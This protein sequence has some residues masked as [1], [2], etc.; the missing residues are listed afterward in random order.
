MPRALV[1]GAG[2][3]IGSHLVKR[4]KKDGFWVRGADLKNPEFSE[5]EADDFQICD[6]RDFSQ[7]ETIF[8]ISGAPFDEVY[9][10]AAD[11]GGATYINCGDNDA[12]VVTNS[13]QINMN[14]ARLATSNKVGK[15][16]FSSSA[17]VYNKIN[18]H[19]LCVE[20]ETYPA[21]PDNE[22]GWEKIFSER[23]F[24]NYNKNYGLNV[25][26]ARFHSIIGPESAWTGG[27]EK[28]HSAL[29]R[30][31][32]F[33]ENHGVVD[34]IGDGTQKRTFLYIDD[35][36]DA[37]RLLMNKKVIDPVNIGSDH[38]ISITNYLDILKDIS[39]KNF[40]INYISGP[41]GIN[42]R[43]CPI[44]KLHNY[45]KWKPSTDISTAT[46]LTYK[47]IERQKNVHA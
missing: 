38:L 1:L 3:F 22:Y 29:A 16:F 40:T 23:M 28:A 18:D 33:V 30:K 19:A 46:A 37:I 34:V 24:Q 25:Q 6:L 11:M 36:L 41:T 45:T 31:V 15:L 47:W 35:C 5:T 43:E 21:F 14:T 17:C 2:G 32:A 13:A 8:N 44:D 39:G 12:D 20:D 10:L 9:Q 4:L 26:I 27:K 7:C 42:V